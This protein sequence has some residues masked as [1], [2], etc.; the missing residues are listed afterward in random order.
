MRS[1]DFHPA[2]VPFGLPID[3]L[4]LRDRAVNATGKFGIRRLRIVAQVGE[5]KLQAVKCWIALERGAQC[6]A[7]VAAL[8]KF[9]LELYDEIRVL[10]F[11]HEPGAALRAGL[12]YAVLHGPRRVG[13]RPLWNFI[14]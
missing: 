14:P 4:G 3:L 13:T 2:F 12:Q 7:A 5:L 6:Q 8:S 10:L 9:D 11:T 1:F